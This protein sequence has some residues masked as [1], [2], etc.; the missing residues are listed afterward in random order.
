MSSSAEEIYQKLLDS[1]FSEQQLEKEINKKAEEYGG[2]MTKQGILFII[3]RE[4]GINIKSPE[5]DPSFYEVVENGID[6][7][8]FTINIAEV[9]EG[10]F[11]IVLF[12]KIRSIVPPHEFERKDGTK[13]VVGSCVIGD[14][15]GEIKVVLWDDKARGM[16]SETFKEGE[17]VHILADYSKLNREGDIEVH[18]GKK[19]KIILAPDD[20]DPQTKSQLEKITYTG[21]KDDSYKSSNT[22]SIDTLINTYSFIKKIQGM[23][24][25]EEF[26]E[27]TKKDGEKTFLLKLVLSDESGSVRVNIWGMN[28]VDTLKFIE[29]NCSIRLRNVAVKNNTFTNEK[30][31][32]F[33]RKSSLEV[34]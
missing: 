1:G 5:I 26:K 8:E 14:S 17:I 34:L 27:I 6:Y 19:G 33:T 25:I 7:D 16:K 12:G 30:E 4:Y 3:A 21:S 23:V 24:N 13:G 20:I 10:M 28:A 32:S 29:E 22:F 15:S 9:K 11:S 31:L 18:V 2:F